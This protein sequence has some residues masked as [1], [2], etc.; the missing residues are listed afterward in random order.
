[1]IKFN[2]FSGQVRKKLTQTK[3]QRIIE[4]CFSKMTSVETTQT[5]ITDKSEYLK[6]V[7]DCEKWCLQ[8]DG[9]SRGNPGL[10]GSGAVL[11]SCRNDS[12]LS[13][14][15]ESGVKSSQNEIW[16]I[17]H[18]LGENGVTNNVAE[19]QG[20]IDGLTQA[21]AMKVN[22]LIIQG[23]SQLVLRQI[24]GIYKT[25]TIHLIPL[26]SDVKKLLAQIP[27]YS[28]EHIPREQ[29][30]RADELSNI[31]MDTKQTSAMR[32]FKDGSRQEVT[33]PPSIL[34]DQI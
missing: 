10:G 20:L 34:F 21:V 17:Y 6:K 11:F 30:C 9:G 24:E 8:F 5:M 14:C 23:D 4:R 19:Y 15:D 32:V 13:E 26:H 33:W 2:Q 22:N 18:F 12:F 7:G 16:N 29:N 31:A 27:N 3:L 25:R 1:M 28:L